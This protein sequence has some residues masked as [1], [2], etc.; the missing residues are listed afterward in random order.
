MP[1]S[2]QQIKAMMAAY[3]AAYPE[4]VSLVAPITDAL[5][6]GAQVTSRKEFSGH[7]TASAILLGPD[8]AVL[9]VHHR[10]LDRWLCPGGHLEPGDT[11]FTAAALRELTEETGVR[12]EDV[13]PVRSVPVHIDVHPI[14]A[15]EVK[16][17]PGHRHFDVRMLFRVRRPVELTVQQEEVLGAAWRPVDDI[18][19]VT[20]RGRVVQAAKGLD[21]P[22]PASAP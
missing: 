11:D 1:V 5:K 17:E 22:G 19:H 20:L 10:A 15:N 6:R 7:L 21:I 3:L 14:P 18:A 8:D 16:G 12:A 4:S 2:A 13:E 9:L